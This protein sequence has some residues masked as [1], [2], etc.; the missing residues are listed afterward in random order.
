MPLQNQLGSGSRG[1]YETVPPKAQQRHTWP[2]SS[3]TSIEN[4]L[5]GAVLLG[6]MF[7]RFLRVMRGM[8]MMSLSYLGVVRCLFMVTGFVMLG[9]FAVVIGRVLMM[10]G[11]FGMVMCSF[12][13][14]GYFLS[15]Q[16]FRVSSRN[17]L[18]IVGSTSCRQISKP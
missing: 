12:L 15:R 3:Q 14:H 1:H 13:R 16:G 11:G 7:G 6:M 17:L 10:I 18:D 9:S 8:G 5:L 2:L 4:T